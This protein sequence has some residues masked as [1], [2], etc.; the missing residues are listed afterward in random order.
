[1]NA[2]LLFRGIDLA[3]FA[4]AMVAR[5]RTAGVTVSASGQAGFVQALQHLAPQTTVSLYWPPD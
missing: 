3:A 5:L 4:A 1:V 2:P